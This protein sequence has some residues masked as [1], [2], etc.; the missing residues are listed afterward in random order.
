MSTLISK[1][2]NGYL[3][4]VELDFAQVTFLLPNRRSTLP[5]EAAMCIAL[6]DTDTSETH[7][8]EK[9]GRPF[10]NLCCRILGHIDLC[11]RK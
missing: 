9:M 3:A 10:L 2:N 6:G 7:G 8:D 1:Q 11:A 4:D 5:G